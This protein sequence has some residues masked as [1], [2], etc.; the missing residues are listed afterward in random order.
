MR[1]NEE[2]VAL[3]AREWLNRALKLPLRQI[4]DRLFTLAVSIPR[5]LKRIGELRRAPRAEGKT[6]HFVILTERL[7]DIVAAEPTLRKIKKPDEFLVW[8]SRPPFTGVVAF[9]PN[10]DA[11]LPVSSYVETLALRRLVKNAR[12]TNLHVDGNLCNI[13]GVRIDNP[14]TAG[15]NTINYYFYGPLADV[16]SLIATGEKAAETPKIHPDPSFDARAFLSR[17]FERPERPLLILHP[18]SDEAARS[19]TAEATLETARWLLDATDVNILEVGLNPL[20]TSS[21]RTHSLGGSLPLARQFALF[22]IARMFVGVDSGF[23][24]V[25][26]AARIESILLLGAYRNFPKY[27]PVRPGPVDIV[28]RSADQVRAIASSE[29]VGALTKLPG[30]MAK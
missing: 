19:W 30:D 16:Y 8:L 27:L 7:G 29:V 26:N 23:A 1:L 20:L 11:V 22:A 12:W 21:P 4:L 25:A 9:N 3:S 5:S 15:I 13:F 2:P 28:L 6:L 14:T 10:V 18:A 17:V 24:H